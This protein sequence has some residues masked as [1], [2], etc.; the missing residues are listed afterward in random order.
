MN[1]NESYPSIIYW[2]TTSTC[3]SD[4][5]RQFELNWQI[6]TAEMGDRTPSLPLSSHLVLPLPLPCSSTY[7]L[8]CTH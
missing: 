6:I 3:G 4:F 7:T 1:L 2:H 8:L 5:K